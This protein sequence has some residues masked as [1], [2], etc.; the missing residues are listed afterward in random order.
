ML[1]SPP[2]SPLE[3]GLPTAEATRALGRAL[4]ACAAPGL[5]IDLEGPLGAGKT[6]LAKAFVAARSGVSED[7]VTS[8]TF[9][10]AREYPGVPP[11]LHLDA[12]RL[13]AAGD[14][15]TLGFGPLDEIGS[16]VLIEWGSRVESA[17]P[18]DRVVVELAHDDP[19]RRARILALGPRS[20]RALAGLVLPETA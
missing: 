16:V 13:G 15:E 8:P 4:A 20:E 7:D 10:L 14:V 2:V 1:D 18:R 6:S 3:L 19:G 11:V 5:L 17:L 9:A 12:Y